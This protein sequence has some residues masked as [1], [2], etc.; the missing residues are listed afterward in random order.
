MNSSRQICPG[1]C[2]RWPSWRLELH[3]GRRRPSEGRRVVTR[4]RCYQLG[5]ARTSPQAGRGGQTPSAGGQT[6][7]I[8]GVA[9]RQRCGRR[10]ENDQRHGDCSPGAEAPPPGAWSRWWSVVPLQDVSGPGLAAC[11]DLS[12]SLRQIAKD[13]GTLFLDMEEVVRRHLAGGV[14]TGSGSGWINGGSGWTSSGSGWTGSGSGW[15]GSGSGW[16][17]SGSGWTSND[18]GWTGSGSGW[19][20]SGSGW[21]GSGSGWTGRGSG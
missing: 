12:Q 11:H 14:W 8:T 6:G 13:S 10:G 20:G 15:T 21:T 3:P 9:V 16:T 17:N 18:T 19:T 1:V 7:T 5:R 2:R 4:L